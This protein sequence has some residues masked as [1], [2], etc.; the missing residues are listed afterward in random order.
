MVPTDILSSAQS[1]RFLIEGF[2]PLAD[3]LEWE[4]G[5]LYF[6]ERGSRAFASGQDH[7][8]FEINNN[9]FLSQI[10]AETLYVS[11]VE[12]ERASQLEDIVYIIEL[13]IGCGLFARLFLDAFRDI[14]R[15]SG[16]D[17]YDRIHYIATDKSERMLADVKQ[18]A[19]FQQHEDLVSVVQV[20]AQ[21][22]QDGLKRIRKKV[23]SENGFARAIFA[24]YIL[25]C[26]PA[27]VLEVEHDGQVKQLYVATYLARGVKL[28]EH[29]DLT[30]E[31]IAVCASSDN[32]EERRRLIDLYPLFALE[33]EYRTET[34]TRF[35]FVDLIPGYVAYA[36]RHFVHNYGA[37]TCLEQ[38][39]ELLHKNGFMIINDYGQTNPKESAE[40]VTHQKFSGSSAIGLNFSLLKAFCESR[41]LQW[42]EPDGDNEHLISRLVGAEVNP[43]TIAAFRKNFGKC[44]QDQSNKPVMSA[45]KARECVMTENAL[46]QYSAALELQPYNWS[47]MCEV[48][49]FLIFEMRNFQ[50]GVDMALAGLA[51]NGS[52]SAELWNVL[53]DGLFCLERIGEARDAFLRAL[54]V[55]PD[56]TRARFNM[57]DYFI[58]INDLVSAMKAVVDG[59]L[60]DRWCEYRERLLQKQAEI[61]GRIAA[62]HEMEVRF[63]AGRVNRRIAADGMPITTDAKL[64]NS[65]DPVNGQ[66]RAL[67]Y[68]VPT[69]ATVHIL[70]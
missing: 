7:V 49:Q 53:G 22:P 40:G 14:C 41:C 65:N 63:L 70:R 13:G 56:D 24:N 17:Y 12:A 45:R 36:D 9:G 50:A 3:S 55:D 10:A 32:V 62:R 69:S 19:V 11:L 1:G 16:K 26:L 15:V 44:R 28:D 66:G 6:A 59:L 8:P 42:V 54:E 64:G 27:A 46:E 58:S 2:Q 39:T 61:L 43:E 33:Y 31:E 35:P 30:A 51:L 5:Q 38:L 68:D 52:C 21:Y 18:N 37:M 67:K 34:T 57:A 48:A 47:V 4:L 20:D 60:H 25:D 23:L 29:T